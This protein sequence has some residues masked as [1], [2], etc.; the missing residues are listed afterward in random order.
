MSAEYYKP[1][2]EDEKWVD[3][4]PKKKHSWRW[5]SAIIIVVYLYV[6]SSG[7]AYLLADKGI[8]AHTTV[9]KFY[10]PLHA[11]V[12]VFR[13]IDNLFWAYVLMW[14]PVRPIPDSAISHS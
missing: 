3:P 9:G 1:K 10:Q 2:P 12:A 13:P 6:L 8:I 11:M 4:Y 14:V 5:F 7:P